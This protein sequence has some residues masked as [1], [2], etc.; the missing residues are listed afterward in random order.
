MYC[1]KFPDLYPGL[2]SILRRTEL[3]FSLRY[4]I[5]SKLVFSVEGVVVSVSGIRNEYRYSFQCNIY[6]DHSLMYRPD[7]EIWTLDAADCDHDLAI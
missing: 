4:N 5:A 6:L 3:D 1:A 7:F 2:P